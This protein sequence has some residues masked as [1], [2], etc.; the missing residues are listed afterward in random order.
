MDGSFHELS[1]RKFIQLINCDMIQE[2]IVYIILA[3][4]IIYTQYAIRKKFLKKT[5]P[6]D[7][8][9]GCDLKKIL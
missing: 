3:V 8:C 4:T 9:S 6:C 5:S 1:D 2:I 7:G